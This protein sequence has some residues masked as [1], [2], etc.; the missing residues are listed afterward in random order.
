M[1]INFSIPG[2]HKGEYDLKTC[3]K[4]TKMLMS[5]NNQINYL[6]KLKSWS[7]ARGHSSRFN[8]PNYSFLCIDE[9]KFIISYLFFNICAILCILIFYI[10]FVYTNDILLC[11]WYT[12]QNVHM[13]RCSMLKLLMGN[14]ENFF[15]FIYKLL[16]Y[17]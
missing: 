9:T 13:Q 1:L 2:L 14:S 6:V 16:F 17:T 15:Q 3:I 10:Q 7:V 11:N 4:I 5:F 12:I 8:S